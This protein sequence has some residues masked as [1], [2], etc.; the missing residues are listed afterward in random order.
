MSAETDT[1]EAIAERLASLEPYPMGRFSDRGIVVCVGGVLMFANAYVLVRVLR[2]TLQCAL[3]IQLW[4]L[5]P[6]ELSP[7]MRSLL[8]G[9]GVEPID[10]D[11]VRATHPARIADGWQLKPYAVLNSR[12][13]EVLLLDA[14]QVPVRDPTEVFRWAQYL[15]T[16]ALFWPDIIDLNA[17]NPVWTLCGLESRRC[18]S[19]DSGQLVVD[20]QRHWTALNLTLHLNEQADTFYR[21]VYGDKDTFLIGWLLARAPYDLVPHRPFIDPRCLVQRDFDGAAMFQHRTNA[22]WTYAGPQIHIQNFVHEQ[23]CEAILRDLR[24]AWNG[25]LFYP[26]ERSLAARSAEASLVACGSMRLIL[27]GEPDCEVEFLPGHQF[28]MGRGATLQNWYVREGRT[29]LALVL[30]D[31]DRDTYRF[32][33][34]ADQRWSGRRLIAPQAEALLTP[35]ANTA[36]TPDDHGLIADLIAA[37]GLATCWTQ[38]AEAELLVAL[39]LVDRANPGVADRLRTFSTLQCARN[40]RLQQSLGA[41]ADLLSAQPAN[42]YSAVVRSAVWQSSGRYTQAWRSR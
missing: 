10:A 22:K 18:A 14:D 3:P 29:G 27:F 23:A 20:K 25:R 17:D 32:A 6:R 38:D 15:R 31:T 5:G 39:R 4:H 35:L 24:R 21:L 34:Q 2:D 28:G 7:V 13:Q 16:G 33:P 1:T 11:A 41:I 19:L 8:E 12:F 42:T 9:L 26:P 37:S 36:P 30:R 40:A